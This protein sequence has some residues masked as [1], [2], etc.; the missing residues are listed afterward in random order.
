MTLSGKVTLA[1]AGTK[2]DDRL[3]ETILIADCPPHPIVEASGACGVESP[4]DVRW[5]KIENYIALYSQVLEEI[6]FSSEHYCACKEKLPKLAKYRFTY[7]SSDE[8]VYALGQCAKCRTVF[9]SLG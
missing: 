9:W 7:S 5:F 6:H 4:C 2:M 1:N 3:A 8:V